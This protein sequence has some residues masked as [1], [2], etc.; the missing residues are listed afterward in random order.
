MANPKQFAARMSA[1]ARGVE[2]N[3]GSALRDAIGAAIVTLVRLTPVGGPPTSPHDTHP[4][5]ARSNWQVGREG[6]GFVRAATS[7][8][9][10]IARGLAQA[11]QFREDDEAIISNAS[12]H[13][14]AL[15]NGWSSQAPAGFANAAARI[16][17][18]AARGVRLLGPA[19]RR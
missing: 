8:S 11:R 17:G 10:A 6:A 16:A 14:N 4:G 9:D 5:L 1:L 2:L 7:E 18:A 12:P 15:N 13:I 3:S 19:R